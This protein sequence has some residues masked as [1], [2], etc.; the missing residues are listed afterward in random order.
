MPAGLGWHPYFPSKGAEVRADTAAIWR[1]SADKIPKPPEAVLPEEDLRPGKT[2]SYLALDNCFEIG[3]RNAHI[4][5]PSKGVELTLSWSEPGG[6]LIVFTPKGADF[7]CVEPVTHAP[8]A[9]NSD[10]PPR[11]TGLQRLEPGARLELKI[12]LEVARS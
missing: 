8:D 5:W 9:V 3:A 4:A 1:S 12:R 10:L 6:R 2:V 11:Q 7:F